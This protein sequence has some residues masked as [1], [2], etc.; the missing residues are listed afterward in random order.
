MAEAVGQGYVFTGNVS[1]I[2]SFK[3]A[4]V[5]ITTVHVEDGH[6]LVFLD[7]EGEVI[8]SCDCLPMGVIFIFD[9]TLEVS[10]FDGRVVATVCCFSDTVPGGSQR[11]I[12]PIKTDYYV[13]G[14]Y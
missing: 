5:F 6:R 1:A 8:Y 3:D 4:G 13:Q 12:L 9:F 2:R 11:H 7:V 14:A 10:S